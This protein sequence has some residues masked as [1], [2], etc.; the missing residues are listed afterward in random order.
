MTRRTVLLPSPFLGPVAYGPLAEE[1]GATIAALPAEPFTAAAVLSAF[2]AQVGEADLVVA[3]SNAGLYAPALGLPTV[4]VDAALPAAPGG[5][6]PLAP[7]ALADGVAALADASGLLPPWT[8]WWSREDFTE[9]LPD[10]WF[11][12][13]DAAAPRV[14]ATYLTEALDVPG[15]WTTTPAAYLAFGDTYADEL[16]LATSLGWPTARLDGGHL[17][18]LTDPVAVARA[19]GAF[20]VA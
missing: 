20:A 11:D 2:A 8:R 7:P 14:P 12:R 15:G 19:V 17:L 6:T 16:E 18:L 13:V 4:F 1:L 9:V 10:P 3:H 5:R